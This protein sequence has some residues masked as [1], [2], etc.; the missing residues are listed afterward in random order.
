M[1]TGLIYNDIFSK[2]LNIFGSHW[3]LSYNKSTV[4]N[5]KHLQLSPATSDYEGTPYPFGMDPIWQVASSNKIVFQNAYKMKISIIFGVLHMIFGVIM[6]WHNHTYFRNRLSLLYE[7]IP[8]LV[9]LLLLFFYMVLLMFI[10]WNRYAA[11]NKCKLTL[12]I[13]IISYHLTALLLP[14]FLVPLTESCAP[15]ILIT[16]ID[17]VLFNEPKK[18]AEGCETVYMFWGQHFIQIVFVLIALGCIPVML[19]GKPIKI[20][21]ARKLANVSRLY[22]G[23]S[24]YSFASCIHHSSHITSSSLIT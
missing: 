20:M 9:F 5:N 11:T 3:H 10:K 6:S 19:L 23:Y 15:S 14:L 12:L 22:Y 1:Y 13:Y 2:S 7:F 18:P 21:Q 16:F 4:F 8:Q 24:V 17:M